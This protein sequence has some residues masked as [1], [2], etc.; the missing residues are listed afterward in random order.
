MGI[1]KASVFPDPVTAYKVLRAYEYRSANQSVR[2][3]ST[4]TSL[5]FMKSGIAPAWT[6]VIVS[7]P[8]SVSCSKLRK[9]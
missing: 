5:F 3:T 8:M 7:K 9:E 1:T 4:T 2:L 6:G